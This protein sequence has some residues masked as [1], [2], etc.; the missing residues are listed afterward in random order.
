LRIDVGARSHVGRVRHNNE[1]AFRVEPS[2]NLYVL[3]D[4]MGGA[5]HGEVASAE[6]VAAVVK[7]CF[8]S[9]RNPSRAFP[10]GARP[11]LSDRT[12]HL[13]SAVV[14][15]NRNIFDAASANPILDGMGATIVAVWLHGELM[16]LVHVGDSRAY[17]LRTG[18]LQQ[19][20]Y[21]HSLVAEQV[22][23]GIL[24]AQEGSLSTEQSVLTRAV[25]AERD[26]EVEADE[27]VMIAGDTL[28][29]CSDGLTRMVSDYQIT[30]TLKNSRRAQTAADQLVALANQNGGE[31]NVTVIVVRILGSI[32]SR[33]GM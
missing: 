19:L 13:V 15:A 5:G 18:T 2:L 10:G 23:L 25:G 26:V 22:R 7:H 3:S 4:G 29:L 24:T 6:A 20:T 30:T 27:Q 33:F 12:N 8:E 28:L 31:D 9:Q 1:D 21:D 11:D 32:L 14:L 16:S 17:L